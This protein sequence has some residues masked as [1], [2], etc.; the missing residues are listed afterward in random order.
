MS[1]Y[2]LEKIR[3]FVIFLPKNNLFDTKKATE[4]ALF[5]IF[6]HTD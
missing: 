5:A 1:K 4:V 2:F 3:F 6:Y